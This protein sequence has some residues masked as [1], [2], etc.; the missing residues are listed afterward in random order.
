MREKGVKPTPRGVALE[1]SLEKEKVMN[2]EGNYTVS[3][4][5]NPNNPKAECFPVVQDLYAPEEL[6]PAPFVYLRMSK[7]G[8]WETPLFVLV[9][10]F[11]PVTQHQFGFATC[12]LAL[13]PPFFLGFRK[14]APEFGQGL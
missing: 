6:A 10:L 12:H 13:P 5:R 11:L 9:Y 14:V 3:Y 1:T 4:E 2:A 8:K 7:I